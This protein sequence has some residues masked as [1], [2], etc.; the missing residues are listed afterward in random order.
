MPAKLKRTERSEWNPWLTAAGCVAA[1]F[2]AWK[3]LRTSLR[4]AVDFRGMVVL[5]TGG[6]RGLGL[7]LASELGS[8][9]ARLAL[10]AR[11]EE[12]L[13]SARDKLADLNVECA[14][15][16]ADITQHADI[17]SLVQRVIEHFG[18]IDMLVNNAGK[19]VVGPVDAFTHAD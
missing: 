15:F 13:R 6:S 4:E 5:I 9:G 17:E 16:T 19:I 7:A 2:A 11:D 10:C 12:E 8:C 18:R 14:V 1:G 3:F